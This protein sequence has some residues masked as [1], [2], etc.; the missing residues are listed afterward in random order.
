MI[1]LPRRRRHGDTISTSSTSSTRAQR[2]I[3]EYASTHS[4]GS[5]RNEP[6]TQSDD[7]DSA[8]K[9]PAISANGCPANSEEEEEEEEE[10]ER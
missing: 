1:S 10:E 8:R 5:R 2:P 6:A 3:S 9:G 7:T 4:N